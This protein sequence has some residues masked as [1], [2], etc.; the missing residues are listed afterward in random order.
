[1]EDI[2]KVTVVIPA[3]NEE[4]GIAGV[5]ERFAKLS[6]RDAYEVIV[7]NDG[8]EDRTGKIAEGFSCI[9][10]NHSY[11]KGYGAAIKTGVR[12]AKHEI[13]VTIDA[14]GQHDPA[15]IR[16]LIDNMEGNDMVV[17]AR[18]GNTHLPFT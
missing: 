3:Y 18:R 6:D 12:A 4:A 11:N 13:V 14:D 16:R 15:D 8:S 1:M 10:L 5:L 9:V 17:G 2:R 7:V